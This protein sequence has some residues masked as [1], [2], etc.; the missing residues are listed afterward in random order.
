MAVVLF[1]L[2]QK[3]DLRSPSLMRWVPVVDVGLEPSSGFSVRKKRKETT[4]IEV[5]TIYS[6]EL[7][8]GWDLHMARPRAHKT[9]KRE[10]KVFV[11]IVQ[12]KNRKK[13]DM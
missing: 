2:I 9:R 13:I 7:L 4:I 11:V 5:N 6:P 10:S 12:T 8:K 3:L 1:S